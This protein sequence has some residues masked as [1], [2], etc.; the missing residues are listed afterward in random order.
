MSKSSYTD[1]FML[2]AT[3]KRPILNVIMSNAVILSVE[4]PKPNSTQH[5]LT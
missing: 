4:A 1:F 5:K 2:S 3:N